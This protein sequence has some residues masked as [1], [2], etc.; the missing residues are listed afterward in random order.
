MNVPLLRHGCRL[1][2]ILMLGL[3]AA[4][5]DH[6]TQDED[7]DAEKWIPLFDGRSLDNWTVK[8]RGFEVGENFADT[9]RVEEGLLKV[10]YDG[11]DRWDNRYGHLFYN[12]TFSHY[13]LRVEYRFTGRQMA[14][15]AGWALLNSGIM[16][17]GQ[18]PE[19]MHLDQEFPASLE[20][21][22]LAAEEGERPTANLCTPGTDVEMEGELVRRHCTN[23]SSPTFAPGEWVTVEVEVRGGEQLRHLVN[24]QEVIRYANPVLDASDPDAKKLIDAGAAVELTSGTI[25]LQSESHP[26]E[27]RRVELL[28]LKAE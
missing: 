8:I 4:A 19:S 11:Y 20:V 27:F 21:Q 17:H 16:L 18:S 26:V 24:G 10:S 1:A 23:S 25:S 28:P 2:L 14:G 12:D 13:R 5:P 22:L 3:G 9:F 15:G 7:A 6:A